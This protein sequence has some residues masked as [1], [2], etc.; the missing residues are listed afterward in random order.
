MS[1]QFFLLKM[2]FHHLQCL[3]VFLAGLHHAVALVIA[4]AVDVVGAGIEKREG[5]GIGGGRM[6]CVPTVGS[7]E[8]S[9]WQ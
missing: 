7:S 9:N 1:H 6:R 5:L 2:R 8:I 3:Q 4:C